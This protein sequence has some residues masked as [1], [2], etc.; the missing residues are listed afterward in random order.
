MV[1]HFSAMSSSCCLI[2]GSRVC[3]ARSSHSRALAR[4]SSALDVTTVAPSV[5]YVTNE[6]G[7]EPF[8]QIRTVLKANLDKG[9]GIKVAHASRPKPARV[10]GQLFCCPLYARADGLEPRKCSDPQRMAGGGGCQRSRRGA[11]LRASLTA[12]N[13]KGDTF[14]RTE[15]AFH[16]A[17]WTRDFDYSANGSR[18]DDHRGRC[19]VHS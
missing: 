2:K 5:R 4:Y 12:C 3:S 10:K 18:N 8:H 1:R 15:R 17:V 14:L 13:P 19:A 16:A 9:F 7:K 11:F 6:G